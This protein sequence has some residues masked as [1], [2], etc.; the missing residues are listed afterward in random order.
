MGYENVLPVFEAILFPM[1]LKISQLKTPWL[2]EAESWRE[3]PLHI[4]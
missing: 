1:E 3:F 4:V 2:G